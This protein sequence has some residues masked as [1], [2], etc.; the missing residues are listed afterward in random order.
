MPALLVE[1]LIKL[2][3]GSPIRNKWRKGVLAFQYGQ[4]FFDTGPIGCGHLPVQERGGDG[5]VCG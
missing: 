5:N 3:S 4:D 2:Y 1:A